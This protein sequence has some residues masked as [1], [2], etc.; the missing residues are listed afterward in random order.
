MSDKSDSSSQR[1]AG[2]PARQAGSSPGAPTHETEGCRP[3]SRGLR[4]GTHDLRARLPI[5]LITALTRRPPR[6]T[7]QQPHAGE[8]PPAD[9]RRVRPQGDRSDESSLLGCLRRCEGEPPAQVPDLGAG[10]RS[11][12]Q[13]WNS[14]K[15]RD[16]RGRRR[17][18]DSSSA[19]REFASAIRDSRSLRLWW[20][21]PTFPRRVRTRSDRAGTPCPKF[22]EIAA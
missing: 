21:L 1:I 7:G 17:S 19:S 3:V 16:L 18:P 6:T 11:G 10:G 5:Q 8:A 9:Q 20:P 13:C 2:R 22:R 12:P 15:A 14:A 4:A